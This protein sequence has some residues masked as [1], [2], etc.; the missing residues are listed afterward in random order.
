MKE[1][2]LIENPVF[3]MRLQYPSSMKQINILVVEDEII[4]LN[5]IESQLK[6]FGYSQLGLYKTSDEAIAACKNHQFDIGIIDI[7]L[8]ESTLDGIELTKELN[9]Q[10]NFPVIYLTG[11]SDIRTLNEVATT[12]FTEYIVKPFSPQQLFASINLVILKHPNIQKASDS[13]SIF[14]YNKDIWLLH[15]KHYVKVSFDDITHIHSNNNLIYIHTVEDRFPFSAS[16]KSFNR[17]TNR[18]NII[19]IHK[20]YMINLS[21]VCAFNLKD[22]Q[23]A[24]KVN[25]KNI[26]FPVGISFRESFYK[27]FP[28]LKSD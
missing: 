19:R 21:Y 7:S 23:V 17:Q 14:F 22:H 27:L 3:N 10:Y 28:K 20:S 5:R 24:L 4:A 8:K 15:N 25:D 11:S 6:T 26:W 9:K 12:N 1:L 13:D 16:L 18:E 2:L